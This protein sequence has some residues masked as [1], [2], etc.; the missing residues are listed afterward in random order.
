MKKISDEV[1]K[2]QLVDDFKR[3]V[4]DSEALLKATARHGDD[5]F[6][7]VRARV[8]DSGLPRPGW[9]RGGRHWWT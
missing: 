8:E 2:E 4:S 6:D 7:N 1:T 3:V 5:E 9:R